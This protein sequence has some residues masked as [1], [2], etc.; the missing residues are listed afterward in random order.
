MSD[1]TLSALKGVTTRLLA[2]TDLTDVVGTKIY[3]NVPQ[4][5]SFPYIYMEM[6]SFDWSQQD[7]ANLRH[8]LKIHAYSRNSSPKEVMTIK[9]ECYNA[10][11]RQEENISLDV[12][13]MVILQ[14][15]GI[16]TTFK[17]V[18]GKTWHSVVEFELIID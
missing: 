16:S 4:Q 13:V 15:S 8:I 18:D 12:G 14:Y 17:E 11:N 5:T 6:E 1:T 9:Q 2:Y 10:L 7:D 3:S